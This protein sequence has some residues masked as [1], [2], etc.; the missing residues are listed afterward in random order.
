[1]LVRQLN[2]W[3]KSVLSLWVR[4]RHSRRIGGSLQGLGDATK[5]LD[6]TGIWEIDPII[7][8]IATDVAI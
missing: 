3:I 2:A 6:Q 7:K 5:D 8:R 4:D 1:M